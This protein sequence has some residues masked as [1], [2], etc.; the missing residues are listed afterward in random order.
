MHALESHFRPCAIAHREFRAA[1][2]ACVCLGC[3]CSQPN[4]PA[5]K[6][7]AVRVKLSTQEL[8]AKTQRI[9]EGNIEADRFYKSLNNVRDEDSPS[10]DRHRTATAMRALNELN[11]APLSKFDRPILVSA[12]FDKRYDGRTQLGLLF[13]S[14]RQDVSSVYVQSANESVCAESAILVSGCAEDDFPDGLLGSGVVSLSAPDR[15]DLPY[16][17]LDTGLLKQRLWVGLVD[18]DGTRGAP[19]EAFVDP[20]VLEEYEQR[21]QDQGGTDNENTQSSEAV[22]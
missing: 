8:F 9:L 12:S 10:V 4:S 11:G 18:K 16:L 22:K 3:A 5:V 17:K 7:K 2:L 13:L 15:S 21:Q 20:K 6:P 19:I 1:L 14:I